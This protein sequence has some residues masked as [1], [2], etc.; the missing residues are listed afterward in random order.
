MPSGPDGVSAG[1]R[2]TF[3][4]VAVRQ[5]RDVEVGRLLWVAV[6]PETGNRMVMA[7]SFEWIAPNGRWRTRVPV[8]MFL[9]GDCSTAGNS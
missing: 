2:Q 3:V 4:D 6:E 1:E 8:S 5:Q 7:C 9:R